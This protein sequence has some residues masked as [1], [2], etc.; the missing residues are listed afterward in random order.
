[1]AP[2][3]THLVAVVGLVVVIAVPPA[4][5]RA[6]VSASLVAPA[7]QVPS[8]AST[9]FIAYKCGDSLCLIRPNGSGNRKLLRAERPWPL[10]DPAFSPDGQIVAFRGYYGPADGAYALY[11]AHT[12]GCAV[13]RLT[14]SIAGNKG[15][16][17]SL[18][19]TLRASEPP[20]D[21]EIPCSGRDS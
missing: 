6:G 13:R 9:G 12:D 4:S 15:G 10:W 11:L 17:C 7:S 18:E 14:R 20:T 16:A 8:W 5:M 3:A 21:P 1:M 19:A 2:R